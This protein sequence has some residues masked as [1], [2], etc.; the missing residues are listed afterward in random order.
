MIDTRIV[1]LEAKVA[2]LTALV[3]RITG[4]ASAARRT[5]DGAVGATAATTSIEDARSSRRGMLKLAG[6]AAASAVAVTVAGNASPAAAA[7]GDTLKVGTA[8]LGDPGDVTLLFGGSL[9]VQADSSTKEIFP[10]VSGSN[11][12]LNF[13]TA[14]DAIDRGGVVGVSSLLLGS[15]VATAHG[16]LGYATSSSKGAAVY[17]KS[18]AS[19]IGTSAGVLA[20]SANGP[21][22]QLVPVAA[23]AP[24]TGTWSVGAIQPDTTGRLFYCT[25]S[26]TPGTWIELSLPSLTIISPVRVYDSRLPAPTPGKLVT[27]TSRVV[28][29]KD[30]RDATTGQVLVP[31]IVPA[32][33]TAIVGNLTITKTV[34]S[35]GFLSVVPGEATI[36]SGSSINWFG[37]NQDLANGIT[38]KLDANRQVKVFC[39]GDS[40][41]DFVV[42]VTGY[43]R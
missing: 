23:G 29:I 17:G 13:S 36:S 24:M 31:D 16:V 40:A 25:V 37:P 20:K 34:G 27:G 30:S 41:T 35:G 42:D 38:A 5:A 1:D 19:G 6:A 4:H 8:S 12:G 7:I 15:G 32:G 21:A 33:A 22:V 28:S 43:Y 26:G 10:S 2:E 18:S 9:Q 14:T 11:S 39:G 3:E